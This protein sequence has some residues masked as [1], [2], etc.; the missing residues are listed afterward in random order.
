M[1]VKRDNKPAIVKLVP[2]ILEVGVAHVL[3][4]E[5]EAV[6]VLIEAFS[7]VGE[8]FEGELLA[9]LVDF[10]E[11]NHLRALGFWHCEFGEFGEEEKE[12]CVDMR[13][14]ECRCRSRKKLIF[15]SCLSLDKW[16]AFSLGTRLSRGSR[17]SSGS[18]SRTS[19]FKP[20]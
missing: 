19:S 4:G 3:D 8:E 7:H 18:L 12:L 5:D 10:G 2:D 16:L 17:S 1:R 14:G 13:W 15:A 6:L 20:F 11:V 9:F